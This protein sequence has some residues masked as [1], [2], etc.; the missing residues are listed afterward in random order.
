MKNLKRKITIEFEWWRT[1]GE[2]IHED[3]IEALEESA[4]DRVVEM[5]EDGYTSGELNDV[6]RV[7]DDGPEDGV[8]YRGMWTLLGVQPDVAPRVLV[9]VSGGIADSV[10]DKG[11][12]VEVFDWDNYNDD[13]KGAGPVPAHFRD[14]A[15]P[16]DVPVEGD[17]E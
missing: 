13:P 3:H 16:I 5:A 1:D 14:L 6:I 4:W 10:Y 8:R 11:V 17:E 2:D 12:D 7:S 9:V 15:E